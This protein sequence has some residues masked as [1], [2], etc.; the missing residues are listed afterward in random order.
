MKVR[1]AVYDDAEAIERIRIRGWQ[2]AYRDLYPAQ[3]LDGLEIDWSRWQDRLSNPPIGRSIFV[4][5]D[6][7]RVVGFA[8][9]GPNSDE[10]GIGELSALYVD[11]EKWSCG[12]GRALLARAEACLAETY[13]EA[14][15]WVMEGNPRARRFYELAGWRADGARMPREHGGVAPDSIRYRKLISTSMSRS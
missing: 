13:E 6:E 12:A 9:V 5:E 14:T 11:P 2:I 15:L 4:A 3:Y 10:L 1:A 7:T 8:G